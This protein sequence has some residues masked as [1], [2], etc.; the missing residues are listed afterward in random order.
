MKKEKISLDKF[1]V[2]FQEESHKYLDIYNYVREAIDKDEMEDGEKMPTIRALADHLNV[3]KDTIINAYKKLSQEG[4][5]YQ[6]QG[7]G[8]YIKKKDL[9]KSFKKEYGEIFRKLINSDVDLVDFTGETTSANLFEVKKLKKVLDEVLDRDGVNALEYNDSMGFKKLREVINTKFWNGEN[10]LEN[11]LITSG[12]QQGI[13]IVSK[14][15]INVNDNVV[16][17]KPTYSGALAV[18]KIRRA[19]ILEIPME[20]DGVSIEAFEKILK[21]YRIKCF[22]TMSYFQNPTGISCSLEKKK[23]IIELAKK[24]NFYIIEDDYLS[25]LIYDNKIE[26]IPYRAL[27][28][29][30]VIYLKSFSKVFLPG[31]R[32]GYLLAP[33]EF[34]EA[35]QISK[36]TSDI[37]TSSLMQRA[38]ELY[39]SEGYWKEHIETINKE[40]SKRYNYMVKELEGKLKKYVTFKRPDGGLN[41]FITLNKSVAITSKELFYKLSKRAVMI[42]PG[43]LYYHNQRDGY[44]TFRIGFSELDYKKIDKGIDSIVKVLEGK[45]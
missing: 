25:E 31:I 44:R 22:Y 18:F 40:Y 16:V 20:D 42:S 30:R 35:L 8:S 12:T 19:N 45:E 37:A 2:N 28:K 1:K 17:E 11:L 29:E 3:N 27:N 7:S 5:L 36:A 33:N 10:L 15:L 39:I 4:Y 23:K 14:S 21:K 9:L 26:H 34:S 43:I 32:I 24:Y 41:I 13:D 38:L 6:S